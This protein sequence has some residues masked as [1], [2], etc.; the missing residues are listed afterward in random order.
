ML[1]GTVQMSPTSRNC[2]SRPLLHDLAGDLVAERL[3]GRGGGA[4]AH[5]V[6][7]GTADVGRDRAQDDPVVGL[8]AHPG[9]LRDLGGDLQR[10]YVVVLDLDDAGSL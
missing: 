8:A 1:N 4:P 7:V 2:T 3:P 9:R 6:L 10:G 5:H